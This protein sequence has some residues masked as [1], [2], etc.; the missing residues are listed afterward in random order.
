M[1][2][3]FNTSMLLL[4]ISN[5]RTISCFLARNYIRE[6]LISSGFT[7]NIKCILSEKKEKK[8][9]TVFCYSRDWRL[10]GLGKEIECLLT[11][12]HIAA[13]NMMT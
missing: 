8:I 2:K 1:R 12:R 11:S 9:K 3:T 6:K 10:K 4:S 7:R 13:I 5:Q